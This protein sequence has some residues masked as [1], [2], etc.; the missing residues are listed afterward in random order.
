M[1]K[2]WCEMCTGA[3]GAT[4]AWPSEKRKAMPKSRALRPRQ[5]VNYKDAHSKE[6][7][8]GTPPWL[9]KKTATSPEKEA[10]VRERIFLFSKT[11]KSSC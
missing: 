6:N 10:E 8:T 2:Y 11:N 1:N 4:A 3:R 9:K 7:G 5:D